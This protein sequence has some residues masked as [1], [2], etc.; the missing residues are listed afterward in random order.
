[1]LTRCRRLCWMSVELQFQ[2]D[3][4]ACPVLSALSE[5]MSETSF[6]LRLYVSYKRFC[7]RRTFKR[8]WK[9]AA[10]NLDIYRTFPRLAGGQER[11]S[12]S[13]L[14]TVFKSS[15][16]PS[17]LCAFRVRGEEFP[18]RPHVSGGPERCDG[19]HSLGVRV[20][21]S[22][23]LG[24][25]E[26]VRTGQPVAADQRAAARHPQGHP[27]G[28]REYRELLRGQERLCSLQISCN[29][30]SLVFICL[31][32]FNNVSRESERVIE[33]L[34]VKDDSDLTSLADKP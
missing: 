16:C 10:Q 4:S 1:M 17:L 28:R 20:R 26:D 29:T 32:F 7:V 6:V 33:N 13:A 34:F 21:R 8:L 24:L 11:S 5:L 23:V 31:G 2:L 30:F 9:Q 22:E 18:L 15:S 12:L 3:L 25:L 27:S 14:T 19:N